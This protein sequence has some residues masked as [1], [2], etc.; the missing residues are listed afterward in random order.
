MELT[1]KDAKIVSSDKRARVR[2]GVYVTFLT[3]SNM[4]KGDTL[5]MDFENSKHYF[6]VSDISISGENLDVSAREVGYWARKF[7]NKK[8]FDLRKLIGVPVTPVTDSETLKNVN[9]MSRWC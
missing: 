9:E 8:D 3:A 7:D 6:E 5:E 4:V 2:G 1:I